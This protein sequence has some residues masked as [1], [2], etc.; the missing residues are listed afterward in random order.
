LGEALL[1][2]E[3]YPQ[4][5]EVV[6]RGVAIRPHDT[7][8]LEAKAKALRGL[9]REA[10]AEEIEHAVQLRL[11]EQLALLEYSEDTQSGQIESMRHEHWLMQFLPSLGVT[12]IPCA[13]TIPYTW[14]SPT[15]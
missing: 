9:G 13:P 4:T 15:T 1:G 7:Q 6:E 11:A 2:L 8:L 3:E 10:E 12:A 5:L 14:P